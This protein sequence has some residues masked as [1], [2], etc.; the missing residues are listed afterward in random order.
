MC[1]L[2]FLLQEWA[3]L[4]SRSSCLAWSLSRKVGQL[5]FSAD[6][7]NTW[8]IAGKADRSYNEQ[9][10][11]SCN[12]RCLKR[13]CVHNCPLILGSLSA[14]RYIVI[15]AG[16][17]LTY[18]PLLS[19]DGATSAK[20]PRGTA[21]TP[22]AFAAGK[23]SPVCSHFPAYCFNFWF[24]VSLYSR[25]FFNSCCLQKKICPFIHFLPALI[26]FFLFRAS[27]QHTTSTRYGKRAEVIANRWE[28]LTRPGTDLY[29][30]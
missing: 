21:R 19:P 13:L 10:W 15:S 4:T 11:S 3:R 23:S 8:D 20:T 22:R 14:L 24:G 18:F 27:L 28:Q 30:V 1:V 16:L 17:H 7:I 2:C 29:R 9:Y 26:S 12:L 5:L 25:L 6:A